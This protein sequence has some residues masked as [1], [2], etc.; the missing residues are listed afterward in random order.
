MNELK[1]KTNINCTG[2]LAKVT[3]ILNAEKS[4]ENW[5]VDLAT[6][7]RILT[8]NASGMEANTVKDLVQKAGFWAVEL[9]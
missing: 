7:N 6:E 3:P 4:I 1:F 5:N 2:C 8:V 9:Q